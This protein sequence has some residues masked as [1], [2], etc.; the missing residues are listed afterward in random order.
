[1]G[2]RLLCDVL[3]DLTARTTLASTLYQSKHEA[4][5]SCAEHSAIVGALEAGD[6]AKA[7][8]LMLQHIGN[9]EQALEVESTGA[10]AS[11][12][13]LRATLAPVALPGRSR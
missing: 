8:R 4:S 12:T 3:R 13:R 1:M 6:T 2:H 7:R 5:Q 9:V 10:D 11:D